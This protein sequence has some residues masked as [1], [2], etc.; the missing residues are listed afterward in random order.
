MKK[1]ATVRLAQRYYDGELNSKKRLLFEEHLKNCPECSAFVSN[2][3]IVTSSLNMLNDISPE[4]DFLVRLNEMISF[5]PRPR[6]VFLS[7]FNAMSR[8]FLPAAA[9]LMM[10]VSS[11]AFILSMS[12]GKHDNGSDISKYHQVISIDSLREASTPSNHST[13][14]SEISLIMG[15]ED[16]AA[17]IF[18]DVL[19]GG[20]L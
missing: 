12:D 13:M 15:D 18:Y 4:E 6:L 5:S 14:P 9:A 19:A 3:E 11:L 10:L 20:N 17:V 1:C 7:Y 8:R 16:D 2:C